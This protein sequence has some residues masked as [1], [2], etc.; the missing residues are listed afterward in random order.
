M[1]FDASPR[2]VVQNCFHAIHVKWKRLVNQV[3]FLSQPNN[4]PAFQDETPLKY[5]N[6][7]LQLIDSL[8]WKLSLVA[9]LTQ[10]TVK[11]QLGLV[12]IFFVKV[13]S[14][15]VNRWVNPAS[16]WSQCSSVGSTASGNYAKW[17]ENN[18]RRAALLKQQSLGMTTGFTEDSEEHC[19]CDPLQ[20]GVNRKHTNSHFIRW[21]FGKNAF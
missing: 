3:F 16:E 20:F 8:I 10:Y 14:F 13:E 17:A 21:L 19:V 2:S 6:K 9:A 11:F 12:D 18:S 15:M 7:P 1:L 5:I 4:L